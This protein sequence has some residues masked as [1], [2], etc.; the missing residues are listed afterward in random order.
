MFTPRQWLLIALANAHGLDKEPFSARLEKGERLAYL[1]PSTAEDPASAA[2]ILS[3]LRGNENVRV[4]LDATASGI[5]AL[6]ALANCRKS[7]TA[8]N[9]FGNVCNDAYQIGINQLGGLDHI[10]R[11]KKKEAIMT[12][13]YGSTKVPREN[14]GEENLPAFYRM[15]QTEFTGAWNVFL[16]IQ[17]LWRPDVPSHRWTMPDGF[18]VIQW[19]EMM[20]EISITLW[21]AKTTVKKKVKCLK[22]S[23]LNLAANITHSLDGL[24][25]REM[26]KRAQVNPDVARE[27]MGSFPEGKSVDCDL[28]VRLYRKTNFLSV[29]LIHNMDRETF[30]NLELA[31]KLEIICL[32]EHLANK[33]QFDLTPVHDQF[34][35][36]AMHCND[37]VKMYRYIM[38]QVWDSSILDS[39]V[40]DITGKYEP[41]VKYPQNL[42]GM[43]MIC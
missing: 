4:G 43:Y 13:L 21:G 30:S 31:E 7:G 40:E 2:A 1:D 19:N 11:K 32:L 12:A 25:C 36:K 3:G 10:H 14:L 20:Q 18:E 22:T 39:I 26:V 35:S 42:D 38:Q 37:M 15:L 28:L 27:L 33:D 34:F 8:C 23:G 6:A 17:T 24:V 16:H 9:L 29:D 41:S 5:Q